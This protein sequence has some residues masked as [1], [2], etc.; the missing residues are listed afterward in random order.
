[1]TFQIKIKFEC[2][3]LIYKDNLTG[4]GADFWKLK[5]MDA[6]PNNK[7]VITETT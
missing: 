1:M 6:Y 4:S 5:A 2:C 7:I 3:D